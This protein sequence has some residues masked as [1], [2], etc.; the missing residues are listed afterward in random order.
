MQPLVGGDSISLIWTR[1]ESL[2]LDVAKQLNDYH[3][4][5]KFTMSFS[6]A[7]IALF[8]YMKDECFETDWFVK[9]TD[10]HQCLVKAFK[11]STDT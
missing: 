11:L 6:T 9:P 10:T 5:I 4:T 3:R 7:E 1:G 2:L 8:V